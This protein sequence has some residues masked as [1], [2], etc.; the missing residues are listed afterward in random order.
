MAERSSRRGVVAIILAAAVF[1][2][3][4]WKR[5]QAMREEAL[6]QMYE[7]QQRAF[8]EGIADAHRQHAER[9]AAAAAEAGADATETDAPAPQTQTQTAPTQP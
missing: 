2:V 7:E 3:L 1:G 5:Y 4:G 9:E 6:R 8:Q